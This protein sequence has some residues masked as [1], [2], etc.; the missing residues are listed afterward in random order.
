M[1]LVIVLRRPMFQMPFMA[2][3]RALPRMGGD[4][5]RNGYGRMQIGLDWATAALIVGNHFISAGMG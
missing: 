5:A 4:L 3:H 2:A 1:P